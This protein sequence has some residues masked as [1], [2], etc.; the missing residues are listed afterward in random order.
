LPASPGDG[1]PEFVLTLASALVRRGVRVTVLAPRTPNS[2][3]HEVVADVRVQRF[4]YFPRRWER[5][6]DGAIMANLRAHPA[7]LIQV[8]P[9]VVCFQLAA[10]RIVLRERP[11]VVHAHWIVPAGLVAR[12]LRI[13]TRTPYVVT[14]HGA[15][16]YT[17]RGATARRVKAF[18][19]TGAKATV[20]VSHDIAA[21][22]RPLGPVRPPMPMGVE[23]AQIRADLGCRR[24]ERDRILFVGRLVEKKGVDVLL[25]AAAELPR[26]VVV[27]A[28]GGPLE[29]DLA[30]LADTLGIG[31]RVE[32][33]GTVRRTEVVAQLARASVLALPSRV[34]AGGDQ[35]GVPVV[36][37]E[38]VAAGVPVV[39]SDLGGLGEYLTDGET[40]RLVR[41]GSIS[42]LASA[43]AEMLD[44]P[45]AA[46]RLA[47]RA[48][49][50]LLPLLTIDRTAEAYL[51]EFA[52]EPKP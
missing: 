6:A 4:R 14:A 26:A 25:R 51:E 7:Q 48:S 35:D 9:L 33:L 43:L 49:D 21:V 40:G 42:E 10:L 5:L 44:D 12:L 22:L 41:P 50:D 37:A 38:A 3:R 47:R 11:D 17:M 39:A 30:S 16:A 2:A 1:T 18:V 46:A 52:R 13:A 32:L 15:D 23:V 19:L 20:P 27:V 36:L 24:P 45:D 34:G 31:D 28:G 29:S 8:L